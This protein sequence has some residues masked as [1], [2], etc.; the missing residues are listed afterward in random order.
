M[1]IVI[2]DLDDSIISFM[3]LEE[4]VNLML[5][6]KNYNSKIIKLDLIK[7]WN[8]MKNQNCNINT[9]FNKTCQN[10]YISYAKSLIRRFNIK[11]N[12]HTDDEDAFRWICYNGDLEMAKWLIDLGENGHEKINIHIFSIF[13]TN[14]NPFLWACYNDHLEMAKWLISLGENGYGQINIHMNNE[15]AF[16]F[17][18]SHKNSNIAQWLISLGKNGYGEINKEIIARYLPLSIKN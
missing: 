11:I 18:C 7:E 3:D 1:S 13:F 9:L 6:N 5:T 2:A 14:D 10:K 15:K 16:Q 17:A 12:I 8:L 4:M